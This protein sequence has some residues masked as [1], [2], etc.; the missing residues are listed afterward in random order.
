MRRVNAGGCLKGMSPKPR[1]TTTGITVDR[2][3]RNRPG[4]TQDDK[5]WGNE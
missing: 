4:G 5:K 2:D 3:R 1:V